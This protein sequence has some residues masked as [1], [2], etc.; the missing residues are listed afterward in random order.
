MWLSP[1]V[2]AVLWLC[3]LLHCPPAGCR[4]ATCCAT[5]VCLQWCPCRE[6]MVCTWIHSPHRFSGVLVG[7]SHY[8]QECVSITHLCCPGC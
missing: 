1:D 2:L 5:S 8:T 4:V 7:K 6:G 3:S